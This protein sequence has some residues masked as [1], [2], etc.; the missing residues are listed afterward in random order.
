MV[1]KNAEVTAYINQG[2]G[3]FT[4]GSNFTLESGVCSDSK[5]QSLMGDFN[6]DGIDDLMTFNTKGKYALFLANNP[7]TTNNK[8][9][10][11]TST[12]HTLLRLEYKNLIDEEIYNPTTSIVPG[13]HNIDKLNKLVV[14]Q[15]AYNN[16]I[17]GTNITSYHY[18]G[19]RVERKKQKLSGFASISEQTVSKLTI[20]DY[21]QTYPLFG[22]IKQSREYVADILIN[23]ANYEYISQNSTEIYTTHLTSKQEMSAFKWNI[24][25]KI[26]TNYSSYDDYGNPE[27]I[28]VITNVDGAVTTKTS[29]NKYTND[30]DKWIL[31]RLTSSSVLHQAD[32]SDTITRSSS[33]SYDTDTG[34][35]ISETA[36]PDHKLSLTTYY[37]YDNFGNKIQTA[38]TSSQESRITNFSYDDQGI[39][40]IS[41]TN[42]KGHKTQ[43]AYDSF[44]NLISRLDANNLNTQYQYDSLG[45]KLI[46][47][48]ADGALHNHSYEWDNSI[49]KC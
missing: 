38:V 26:S 31:A 22:V 29:T 18:S 39:N 7:N 20:T 37:Q 47:I 48:A 21:Y 2:K 27:L 8:L 1:C 36:E 24:V 15:V 17:G 14:S 32:T 19:L 3:K 35:L 11:V 5:T 23:Q 28:Q 13:L 9:H 45:R 42:A 10:S 30:T 12:D 34:A 6:H 46:I 16:G 25:S 43:F 44:N 33:F 40:L 4:E 49:G 41:T